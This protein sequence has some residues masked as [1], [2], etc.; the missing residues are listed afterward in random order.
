[1]VD[2]EFLVSGMAREA[3]TLQE[4]K[5]AL[6]QKPGLEKVDVEYFITVL[7]RV[8]ANLKK[9]QRNNYLTEEPLK[10]EWRSYCQFFNNQP[11]H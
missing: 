2:K 8:V 4:A 9:L 1:M 10:S 11:H 7:N 5:Q 6:E 3:K